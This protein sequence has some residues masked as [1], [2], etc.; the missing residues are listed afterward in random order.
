MAQIDWNQKGQDFAENW[1]RG[2]QLPEFPDDTAKEQFTEGYKTGWWN[3]V[4]NDA[5]AGREHFKDF[6]NRTAL[7]SYHDGWEDNFC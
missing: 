6:P 2:S 7:F 3:R 5:Q 4:K 1:A